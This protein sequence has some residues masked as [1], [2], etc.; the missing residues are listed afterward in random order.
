MDGQRNLFGE[1]EPTP[2]LTKGQEVV[3]RQHVRRM[4]VDRERRN[5]KKKPYRKETW[6]VR[7]GRFHGQNPHVYARLVAMARQL[8]ASGIERYG[9]KALYEVLRFESL[10]TKNTEGPSAPFKLNNNFTAYYA[11]LI[12]RQEPDLAGFFQMRSTKS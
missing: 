1:S 12:E 9:I 3:V 4:Q 7:F 6:E 10:T 11:R 8:R 2:G 5:R